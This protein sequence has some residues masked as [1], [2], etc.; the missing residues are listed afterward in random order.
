MGGVVFIDVTCGGGY[1]ESNTVVVA[2]GT[3]TSCISDNGPCG[4]GNA[5]VLSSAEVEGKSFCSLYSQIISDV[6]NDGRCCC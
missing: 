4:V 1:G 3:A 2:N 6:D 5:V